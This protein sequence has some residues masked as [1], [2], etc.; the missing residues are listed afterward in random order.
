M[1]ALA[2]CNNFYASCEKAFNPALEGVP[3]VVLSN[4]DGCCIARSA[5][6]KALGIQMGTPWH[7]FEKELKKKG[8]VAFSSNYALYG[9]MASRVTSVYREHVPHVEV[10]SIDESFLGLDGMPE[11]GLR[12]MC[13]AIRAQVMSY[14]GIPIGVGIGPTK[15][16]AKVANH[17]AKKNAHTGG[18]YGLTNDLETEMVLGKLDLADIWGI[19]PR[20]KTKLLSLGIKTPLD[21]RR[22]DPPFIRNNFTVVQERIC[23]ELKGESCLPLELVQPARKNMC[24]SRS[25]GRFVTDYD[26]MVQ[27]VSTYASRAAEKLRK[28]GLVANHLT[29]FLETN[30]F[31]KDEP[32]YYPAQV[33][34]LSCASADTRR[35]VKAAHRALRVIWRDGYRYKKA[36]ILLGDLHPPQAAQLNLFMPKDSIRSDKLMQAMDR[37]NHKHGR[38]KVILAANGMQVGWKLKAELL[39]PGYTTHWDGLP[40]ANA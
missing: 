18:V 19:A 40:K 20:T 11:E 22:A 38:S 31:N 2:D 35:L 14:T 24:T 34:T 8:V 9:N 26:E 6:A 30:K 23:R 28:A 4:N 37:L 15:T 36:G 16:L 1:F 33:V 27:A 39:S 29:V 12:D 21:L 32:Q 10:Y 3:V 17:Y 25:F 7:L 5:E 13:R